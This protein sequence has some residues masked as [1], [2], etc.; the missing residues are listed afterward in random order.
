[1]SSRYRNWCF[2]INNYTDDD[3]NALDRLATTSTYLVYGKEVGETGTPHLQGFVMFSNPRRATALHSVCPGHGHWTVAKDCVAAAI[4]CKKDGDYKEYG[5]APVGSRQGKRSDLESIRDAINEGQ[6]DVKRLRQDFPGVCAKYPNFVSQLILD[7]VPS[8]DVEEHLLRRWQSELLETLRLPPDERT[9]YF[10]VD[11]RGNSGKTWFTRFYE[12]HK[13]DSISLIPGKKSDMVYAFLQLLRSNTRV[14][15]IDCPRSKIK[16]FQYDFL[17]D[18][19]N[20]RMMNTK[21]E[22]RMFS[23]KVPHVVMFMNEDPDDRAL[24]SDRYDVRE[25]SES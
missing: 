25:A 24:S 12:K 18:L 13:S 5:E 19:K 20:G 1:M 16:L 6:V 7:Q 4:Y 9:V 15:F 14:V 22:S 2:T 11:K 8:P 21:Y 10:Y 23:F 17:E 3:I